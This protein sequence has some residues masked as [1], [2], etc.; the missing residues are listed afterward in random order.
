MLTRI[1]PGSIFCVKISNYMTTLHTQRLIL[2]PIE[3]SDLEDIF[4]YSSTPNVGPNAGW[5]PHANREETLQI[6][7]E[8]FLE[9]EGVWGIVLRESGKMIGSVGLI[10]DHKRQY[11]GVKMIGYAMSEEYWGRGIMSEAVA[12][13]MRFGFEGLK[14][15]AISAYCF[16]FNERSKAIIRKFGFEFEGIL[17]L[18]ERR[19][20]GKVLDNECYIL[21]SLIL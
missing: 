17:K 5:K 18:A 9:K 20:D 2:R 7:K 8:I 6:M 1:L 19:F 4:E 14:L 3:L 12:E 11:E 15:E 21:K 10:D 13:V 16:P